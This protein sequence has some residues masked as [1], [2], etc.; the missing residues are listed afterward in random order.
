M[1]S[2]QHETAWYLAQIKPNCGQ[3]AQRNLM[4]QGFAVFLPLEEQTGRRNGGFYTRKVP[5]FPGYI[6]IGQPLGCTTP[7][8]AVNAT[9]GISRLVAFGTDLAPVPSAVIDGLIRRCDGNGCL[10]PEQ[11]LH[12]GDRVR[13]ASGPFTDLLAEIIATSADRRIWLLLD[14]MGSPTRITI[15]ADQLRALPSSPAHRP[16]MR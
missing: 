16:V 10:I 2:L 9:Q 5:L 1:S 14:I 13:V 4:R 12:S 3:I 15:D 6:F 11:T 7:L 8:R